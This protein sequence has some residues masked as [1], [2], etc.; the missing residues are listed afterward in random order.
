MARTANDI[1]AA[2]RHNTNDEDS[3]AYRVSDTKMLGYVQDG[4][5]EAVSIRPDLLLGKFNTTPVTL[6]GGTEIPFAG[7]DAIALTYY[8]TARAEMA[9]DENVNSNRMSQALTQFRNMLMGA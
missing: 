8:V 5:D 9:D 4:Y 2:A 7:R 6:V 1:I 3:G